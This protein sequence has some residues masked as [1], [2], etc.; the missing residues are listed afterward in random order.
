MN[1]HH[2]QG[3][4]YKGQ[5]LIGAGL[6]NQRFN[7]LLSR[8]EHGSIQAGLVQEE[9]RVLRLHLKSA[10]RILASRQLGWV[11]KLIPTL[12]TYSNK[13]TPTPTG[14]QLLIV[15]LPGPSIYKPSQS[16]TKKPRDHHQ[17]KNSGLLSITAHTVILP[18]RRLRQKDQIE[19]W[20]VRPAEVA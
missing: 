17:L 2:D 9:L 4:S 18:S 10:T 15:L 5:H 20:V 13:V 1:R 12:N 19:L 8:W 6:Q 7:P 16:Y 11:L 3:N 14:P